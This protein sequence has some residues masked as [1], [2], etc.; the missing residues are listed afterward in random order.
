MDDSRRN[1]VIFAVV[2]L[3]GCLFVGMIT[4]VG[5]GAL[6]YMINSERA[7]NIVPTNEPLSN[8]PAI[9]TPALT[10]TQINKIKPSSTPQLTP[11]IDLAETQPTPLE[12]QIPTQLEIPPD[13]AVQMDQIEQDVIVLRNLQPSGTVSRALLSRDQLRQKI[14]NE[15]F[16]DYSPEEAQEDSIALRALGLLESGFDMFTFYQALLSEQI[17]GQYDHKKKEMDIIQG[18]DFGGPERLT[19]A[20]EY[21][22]V[23][24]DQNFDIENGLHYT[25]EACEED[26][27]RCAA[28]QALLEGDASMLELE[29]FSNFATAEDL[30]ELQAFYSDYESPIFNSAPEFLREDFIFPY[31]YGQ[32]FVEHLLDLGG[33]EMVNSVYSDIPVSTEQIIHPERYPDDKPIPVALPDLISVLGDGWREVDRGVLGEWYTY[34]VLAHGLN[35]DARLSVSEAQAASDGWG[36]DAYIV[37]YDDLNNNIVLV[38]HTL[39][40]SSGEAIQFYNSFQKHSTALFSAPTTVQADHLAW[41][42]NDGYTVLRI[43]DQFTTWI[44]APNEEISQALWTAIQAP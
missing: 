5:V 38:V 19:Y 18:F 17:V 12:T 11:A 6:G 35:P 26:S 23:L 43:Q 9:G 15:F 22:H 30:Q 33:W 40:E 25:N 21:A 4:I 41:T 39:W 14:E 27:E 8:L 34:L 2:L 36:G 7:V 3:V 37:Y 32:T 31:I 44:F 10:E 42:H 24:Q 29:W 16:E 13:I 1:L 20:H 28:V